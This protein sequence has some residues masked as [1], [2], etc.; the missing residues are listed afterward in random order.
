MEKFKKLS[1]IFEKD[2]LHVLA[3]AVSGNTEFTLDNW[4]YALE[5]EVLNGNVPEEINH[6]FNIAKNMALYSYFCYGLVV[7]AHLKTYITIERALKL[8]YA[9][10]FNDETKAGLKYLIEIAVKEE[11]VTD[12]GF[13]CVDN[14]SPENNYCKNLSDVIAGLRNARAHGEKLIT[15]DCHWH[16]MNCADFVNQLFRLS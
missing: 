3:D 13:R 16:I 7:E 14:P 12:S 9:Q 5:R 15:H 2:H 4:H 10:H 8:K 11:W 1:D 6:H